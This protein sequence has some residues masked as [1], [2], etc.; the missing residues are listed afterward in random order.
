MTTNYHTAIA[1]GAAANAATFNGPLGT[2]DSQLST[3]TTLANATAG[4]VTTARDSYGTLDARLDALVLSGGNTATLTNGAANAAQKVVTVDSTTGFVAGAYVAYML[5]GG[6]LEYNQIDTVDSPTQITLETNI[7]TGGIAD[8]TYVSMIS[9]SEYLAAQAINHAGSLTLVDTIEHAAGRV[10]NVRAYG[11]TGDG[12]TDDTAAIQAAIAALAI[13]AAGSTGTYAGTLYVPDGTYKITD[14]LVLASLRGFRIAGAGGASRFVW[15]ANAPT[16]AVIEMLDCR[17]ST[18][19]N[20]N[21]TCTGGSGAGALALIQMS[22]TSASGVPRFNAFRDIFMTGGLNNVKIGG[23]TGATDANNDFMLWEN[24]EFNNY[25]EA[26]VEMS[27]ES[28]A[29][30]YLFLNC[31]FNGDGATSKYGIDQGANVS[32]GLQ[33]IGGAI[34]SHTVAGLRLARSGQPHLI[35][36]VNDEGNKK[37]LIASALT[38]I[39][40]TS[41]RLSASGVD[42]DDYILIT[43]TGG[44]RLTITDCVI[45]D[46]LNPTP[47]LKVATVS[48]GSGANGAG[49]GRFVFKNNLVYS[50]LTGATSTTWPFDNSGAGEIL[51]TIAEGNVLIADITAGTKTRLEPTRR[52][53]EYS[54]GASFIQTHGGAMVIR[55]RTTGATLNYATFVDVPPY[56][57][58]T[59]ICNGTNT[60]YDETDVT[61]GDN[62]FLSGHTNVTMTNGSSIT[63]YYDY[64]NSRFVEIGR[65]VH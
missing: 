57:T 52:A 14:T 20:I 46:G 34:A 10:F 55:A 27:A 64:D 56:H 3:V 43:S 16:K 37:F 53:N 48:V 22:S 33:V 5:V 44:N 4:E 19:E 45:G 58:F 9:P 51:P 18:I 50:T 61:N 39:S 42:T 21:I 24:V 23:S 30:N 62:L 13:E 8:N 28:Q 11:A 17:N 41:C 26:G 40:I 36:G 12:S 15:T 47:A 32:A 25:A 31:G 49:F 1:T 29:Y 59:V 65:S 7:G 38:E 2:L 54:T 35:Q 63:F 6:A 60:F